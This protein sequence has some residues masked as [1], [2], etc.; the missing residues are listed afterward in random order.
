MIHDEM[1]RERIRKLAEEYNNAAFFTEDPIIFPKEFL[2]RMNEGK[3]VVQDVEIAA[4][5]AAHL[6]WGRRD[7]IVRDCRRAF[8]EMSWKPFEY[9]KSRVFRKGR[10]SLHRTVTWNEF[11][12]ICG[13]LRKLYCDRGYGSIE[14]LDPDRFRT[15]IYGQK[16]DPRAANKKIHMLR[17]WMVRNDGIVDMGIWKS[18]SPSELVIP[19]DVH[20]HRSALE[21]GI[22]KRKSADIAT[23]M[24][25]T[26]YLKEIFPDDP[27]LGDFALFAYAAEQKKEKERNKNNL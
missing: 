25:I 24:E 13:N 19:L 5:I 10:E 21:M 7:M 16:S 27:C 15:E 2:K 4:V 11:G 6:A 17:R 20:V 12:M 9:I 14:T 8:D 26:A 23:A 1:Y 3:A 18:I 22:T